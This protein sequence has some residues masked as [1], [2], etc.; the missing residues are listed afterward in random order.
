MEQWAPHSREKV[1]R[2]APG[3]PRLVLRMSL[4]GPCK[5]ELVQLVSHRLRVER[6][7]RLRAK[8]L[9]LLRPKV[10]ELHKPQ[11]KEQTAR[12]ER[13]RTTPRRAERTTLRGASLQSQRMATPA[14]QNTGPAPVKRK[15]LPQKPGLAVILHGL[16]QPPR[17]ARRGKQLAALMAHQNLLA[18]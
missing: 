8:Q 3:K 14:R 11:E 17:R 10:P 5:S 18:A 12:G 2:A 16:W 15:S 4:V 9:A 7:L 6:L 13:K 1:Q